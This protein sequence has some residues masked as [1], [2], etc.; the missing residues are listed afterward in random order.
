MTETKAVEPK[1]LNM[2]SLNKDLQEFKKEVQDFKK[3]VQGSLDKMVDILVKQDDEKFNKENP[4]EPIVVD[5]TIVEPIE[6]NKSLTPKHQA[7]FEEY[8]DLNDGFRGELNIEDNMEFSILVPMELSNGTDAWKKMTKEDRRMIV[9]KP[10]EIES[11]IK[12]WCDLVCK[13]LKYD[14][15]VVKK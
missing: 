3:E 10:G 9:L 6:H 5:E 14:K 13:N 4:V 7:I 8:F 12:R 15:T 11:G 1:K 2:M